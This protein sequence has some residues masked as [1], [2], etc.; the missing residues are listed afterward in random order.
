ME[1]N[2]S[3]QLLTFYKFVEVDNPKR[4]VKYL[5]KFCCDIG[6]R[7]R[8]YIGEE[9][10]NAQ[11]TVNSGQKQAL[12]WYLEH[13]KLFNNIPDIEE[14][15]SDV[16]GHKFPKMIVRYKREIV[17]LGE[18][19]KSKD[20]SKAKFKASPDELKKLI[21]EGN[22]EDY[23]IIDMR[24]DYEFRLGHF[25]NAR[26]AGTLSFRET[27]SLIEDYRRKAGDNPV[28]MYCTGGIRCE[29]LAVMLQ[30]SGMDGV[31][32]LEGGVMK[33]VNRFNDGN[34]LGNLYTF[35]DRVSV[36]VGDE[37]TH[38]TIGRCHYSGEL[39][40]EIHNC[41][42]G[43]CNRQIIALKKEYRRHLGF[44]SE[45]CS[46]NASR[47]LNIR[48]VSFDKFDYKKLR[49]SVKNGERTIAEAQK[50]IS[51]N[52]GRELG[53]IKFNHKNPVDEILKIEN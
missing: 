21:D 16:D 30:R 35:D 44:C 34:W 4:E 51:H 18:I 27:E 45:S 36:G 43:M 25:K 26:P 53:K 29:K 31:K 5:K 28:Y 49:I 7:G 14:K 19:Y 10:I 22:P 8:I 20:I 33:Y 50:I 38:T 1:V 12:L 23:L 13:H 24:N 47:D 15:S 17:A 6:I 46:E 32:Q 3:F 2:T 48:D 52:L 37:K 39:T 42:Y 40:D 41:R 11:C 9:G